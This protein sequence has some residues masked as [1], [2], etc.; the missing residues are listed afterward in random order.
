MLSKAF[1]TVVWWNDGR[2]YKK[3]YLTK[4]QEELMRE[5]LIILRDKKKLRIKI[6][7]DE[8]LSRK[9]RKNPHNSTIAHICS[10]IY[11][12]EKVTRNDEVIWR[13]EWVGLF[14]RPTKQPRTNKNNFRCVKELTWQRPI[15]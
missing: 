14:V 12:S 15:S 13:G 8:L 4:S 9:I 1:N 3:E 2:N 5:I 6:L 10:I 11:G 7:K